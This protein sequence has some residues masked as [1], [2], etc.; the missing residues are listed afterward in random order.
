MTVRDDQRKTSDRRTVALITQEHKG[1]NEPE[2][3]SRE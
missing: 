2:S 3:H 1:R